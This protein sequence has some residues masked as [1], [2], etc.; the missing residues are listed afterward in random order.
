MFAVYFGFIV[1][2][3]FPGGLHALS[4]PPKSCEPPTLDSGYFVPNV[5][6]YFHGGSLNY[7]CDMQHKPAVEGWWARSTCENGKWVP[8]PQ[9]IEYHL[10]HYA[11]EVQNAVVITGYQ[12]VFP[13]STT[14][15]YRCKEGYLTEDKQDSKS[16]SC[17]AGS[18]GQVPSC[19][20]LRMPISY[21]NVLLP[22]SCV[23]MLFI[24]MP[25]M[26]ACTAN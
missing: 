14:L 16:V 18:W 10:M 17:R 8:E 20:K 4:P 9:C 11:P 6:L 25:H 1:L 23:V 3:W 5:E 7:A 2:I 26:L 13:A 24:Y 15:E 12:E 22:Y 21:L 19:G